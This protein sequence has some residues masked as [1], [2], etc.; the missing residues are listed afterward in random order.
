MVISASIGDVI[1]DSTERTFNNFPS[2]KAAFK[3]I[4]DHPFPEFI[5]EVVKHVDNVKVKFF[6]KYIRVPRWVLSGIMNYFSVIIKGTFKEKKVLDLTR[7]SED[8]EKLTIFDIMEYFRYQA[9]KDF[10]SRDKNNL[11]RDHFTISTC[12]FAHMLD[13]EE[14]FVDNPYILNYRKIVRILGDNPFRDVPEFMMGVWMSDYVTRCHEEKGL[15]K[16]QK[17]ITLDPLMGKTIWDDSEELKKQI[18]ETFTTNKKHQRQLASRKFEDIGKYIS[19]QKTGRSSYTYR[20][21]YDYPNP[22]LDKLQRLLNSMYIGV[23]EDQYIVKREAILIEL[24][25]LRKQKLGDEAAKLISE[26]NKR[27]FVAKIYF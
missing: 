13:D 25:K 14:F 17:F 23:D 9:M 5:Q 18:I 8:I 24:N 16:F 7:V 2:M 26:H 1:L 12:R 3:N 21:L 4:V 10:V 22:K 19:H 11:K 6:D 27:R 15:A 20:Y